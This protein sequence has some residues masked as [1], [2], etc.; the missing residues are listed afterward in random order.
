MASSGPIRVK[1]PNFVK[2][3]QTITEISR[4]IDFFK[5]AAVRHLGFAGRVFERCTTSD[6]LRSKD[7]TRA[8]EDNIIT[9]LG[10][11]KSPKVPFRGV[12]RRFQAKRVQY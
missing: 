7:V 2:I 10:V 3:G 1:L 11:Q 9:H 4:F 12:N 6:M 8:W 5:M